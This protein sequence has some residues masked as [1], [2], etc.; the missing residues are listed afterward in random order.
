MEYKLARIGFGNKIHV[1]EKFEREDGDSF[2][3]LS[4]GCS[5]S[6]SSF[7]GNRNTL[8]NMDKLNSCRNKLCK[9]S[10]III[11]NLEQK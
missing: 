8:F 10:K 1:V 5:D 9:V 2:F 3:M 11:E 7:A 6:N 4:C